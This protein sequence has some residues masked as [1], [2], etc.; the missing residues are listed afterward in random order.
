M[1]A[2]LKGRRDIRQTAGRAPLSPPPL[3]GGLVLA[4]SALVITFVLCGALVLQLVVVGG[5]Q[6]RSAQQTEFDRLRKELAEGI[7]PTGPVNAAGRPLPAGTPMAYLEIPAIHLRQV[8]AE[9]T[10]AA[11]L[12]AGPGHRRD[13]PFP[14]Q[15]GGSVILGRRTTFGGPFARL[16]ELRSGEHVRVTTG[17][18][19]F[20]YR[21]M[22]IRHD[23]DPAPDPLHSGEGRMVLITAGGSPL[24]PSGAMRVDTKLVVP[25]FAGGRPLFTAGSLPLSERLMQVDSETIWALAMWLQVLLLVAVAGV[26]AWHRWHRAKA[27]VV[28]LPTSVLVFSFTSA[29]AL[30]LL[31]NLL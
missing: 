28:F 21:V 30:R 29:Q 11:T 14:G 17:A 3:P 10:S 15:V 9:G 13:S 19:V 12:F 4:R 20:E 24:A 31:P 6:Q 26:F 23:H 5:F 1:R 8:V 18:G 7:A 22:G 25:G 16:G 27:W 2:P